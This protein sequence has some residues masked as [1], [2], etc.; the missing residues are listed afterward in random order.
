MI[1][2][3]RAREARWG[4]VITKGRGT[5]APPPHRAASQ[6]A[7]VVL[8][9]S[10][11]S[12]DLSAQGTSRA[13]AVT[14]HCVTMRTTEGQMPRSG[15]M[16]ERSPWSVE[17]VGQ[18][19]NNRS[20]PGRCGPPSNRPD[21]EC[22]SS[23]QSSCVPAPVPATLIDLAALRVVRVEGNGAARAQLRHWHRWARCGG[24]VAPAGRTRRVTLV[25][26]RRNSPL[27]VGC[28]AS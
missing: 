23:A 5:T 14:T 16:P 6:P 11:T 4:M 7:A 26:V 9:T 19:V 3:G 17:P 25:A 15:F 28:P 12:M 13:H 24:R 18:F 22:S 8:G 21:A 1:L 20:D 10:P 2:A 27:A